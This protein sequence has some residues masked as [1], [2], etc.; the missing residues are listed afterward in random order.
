MI[1]FET[2][3][4]DYP[5]PDNIAVIVIM[6]GC[7]HN[8]LGCQNPTLQELHPDFDLTFSDQII[9]HIKN[10]CRRNE[11]NKIVL[12]GGDPLNPCNR[13]LTI[14]ICEELG[15]NGYEIC[16]YT[17]YTIEEVKE[18]NLSGFTFIKCGRFDKDSM[19]KSEK[20]DKYIQFVN[21]TQNLFDKNF[22]QLSVD[23]RYYFS[24]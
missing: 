21:T 12:S 16:I 13:N 11:T 19:Q 17:G 9:A 18:M 23:G 10:Q 7:T 20:T 1:A 4:L 3:F 22:N 24:K 6:S 15:N 5:D 14:R 8:C 2:T